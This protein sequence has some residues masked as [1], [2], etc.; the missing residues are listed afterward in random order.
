MEI[1]QGFNRI[2][3]SVAIAFLGL[4]AV[5][6][7]VAASNYVE[8]RREIAVEY[9]KFFGQAADP[10]SALALLD[11][12]EHK[13]KSWERFKDLRFRSVGQSLNLAVM[14]IIASFIALVFWFAVGRIYVAMASRRRASLVRVVGDRG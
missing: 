6:L 9:K 11:G 7:I 8:Y 5:C 1:Q 2:G 14:C 10:A 13:L 4:A 3:L 12:P